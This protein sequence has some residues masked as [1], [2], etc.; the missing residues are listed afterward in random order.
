M[1]ML[2]KDIIRAMAEAERMMDSGEMPFV[3]APGPDGTLERLASSKEV[4]EDLNLVSGQTVN[5][6]IRDA[7]FVVNLENLGKK[8]DKIA[9]DMEDKQLDSN[10]DFRSMM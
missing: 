10:F 8:L 4:M 7:I 5:S 6:I 3:W 9:Q 1:N 2:N